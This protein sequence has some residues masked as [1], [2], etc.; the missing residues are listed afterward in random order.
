M[1]F[2]HRIVLIIFMLMS[3]GK[4][5]I[6]TL[7]NCLHFQTEIENPHAA[8]VASLRMA[9]YAEAFSKVFIIVCFICL[10]VLSP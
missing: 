7:Y 1:P 9:E 6:N 4:I 3:V 2:W 5:E 8:C 10:L